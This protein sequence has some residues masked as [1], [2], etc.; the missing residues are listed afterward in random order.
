MKT[1][2]DVIT[3]LRH[4]SDFVCV[5]VSHCCQYTCVRVP[6]VEPQIARDSRLCGE[7]NNVSSLLKYIGSIGSMHAAQ[8]TLQRQGVCALGIR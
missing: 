1:L 3:T 5:D 6:A 7:I 4:Q 8:N 2:S